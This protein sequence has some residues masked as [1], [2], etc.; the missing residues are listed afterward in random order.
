MQAQVVRA[1]R[2]GEL[3]EKAEGKLLRHHRL[4]TTLSI[5][6]LRLLLQE[7]PS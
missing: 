6:L 3:Q 2:E 1:S 4:R 7:D 5:R